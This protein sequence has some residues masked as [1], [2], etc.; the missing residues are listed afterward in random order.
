VQH[1]FD[2][3]RSDGSAFDRRQQRA[4]QA[5]A[6]GRAE[7]ALE[8][9]RLEFAVA[10]REGLSLGGKALRLLKSDHELS[11]GVVHCFLSNKEVICHLSLVICFL[12]AT[13]DQ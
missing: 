6:D 1:A 13:N 8:R 4:A 3:D 9:L 10:G 7:P 2:L 11:L 5:V 12:R